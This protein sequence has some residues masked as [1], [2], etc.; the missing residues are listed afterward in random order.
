VIKVAL[1]LLGLL[2]RRP[3]AR[4]EAPPRVVAAAEPSPRAELVLLALLGLVMACG[5]GF[6]VVYALDVSR[7]TQWLGLCLGG[8]FAALAASLVVVAYRLTPQEEVEA[9]YPVAAHSHEVGDI[10]TI[11]E[12][13][14]VRFTRKRLVKTAALGAGG[15]LAAAIITPAA[16]FGP[17]LDTESLSRSP[18][19][20]GRR[21]VDERG[22][23]ILA[24]SVERDTFYTAYPESAEREDL[25]A[26]LVV[27]RLAPEELDLP[28][29][30]QGWA[31]EGIV[32][33]SK[34]CTHA[35]CAISLYRKPTFAPTQPRPALVC[36]CHYSTFD[37]AT[38]GT[39]VF[40]PAGRPLPQLPLE[41]D[42]EGHLRAGG[43]YSGDPGPSWW[44]SRE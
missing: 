40:G 16:S 14:G 30:R 23:P 31:V 36:P 11:V 33:Y 15:A 32:A 6:V 24:A 29:G 35:A 19:R 13:S 4:D 42:R 27:V 5:I 43:P 17:V 26:P 18:W 7:L 8:A 2:F 9:E 20:R 44:G 34:I 12:E 41:I 28:E 1:G 37:P 38:G 39:V 3:P 10:A 21:L 22:R 25:A